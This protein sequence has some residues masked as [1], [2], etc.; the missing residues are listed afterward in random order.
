MLEKEALILLTNL[1]Q[2]MVAKLKEPISHVHG[3]FNGQIAIAVA[4]SYSRMIHGTHLSSPL[5]DQ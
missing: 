3:W 2:L 5:I 4:R 1:S